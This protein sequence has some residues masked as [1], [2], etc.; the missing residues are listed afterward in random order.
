MKRH[1]IHLSNRQI[2]GYILMR[3][4]HHPIECHNKFTLDTTYDYDADFLCALTKDMK[5]QNGF[6]W[7]SYIRRLRS[8]CRELERS[9]LLSGRVTS[10]HKEYLGEPRTLKEYQ[11]GN[12]SYAY[13]LNPKKHP[14]YTAM[15]TPENELSFL[16]DYPYPPK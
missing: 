12:P 14:H 7:K 4:A 16:L 3:L 1:R 9:G 2:A 15:M 5:I 10:C 11:F 6:P 13:R 8:V